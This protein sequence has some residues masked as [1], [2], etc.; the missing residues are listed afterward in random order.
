MTQRLIPSRLS[1]TTS[2]T[3]DAPGFHQNNWAPQL[4]T[5]CLALTLLPGTIPHIPPFTSQPIQVLKYVDDNILQEKINFE[6][7]VTDGYAFENNHAK[8]AQ[9][10]FWCIVAEAEACGMKLNVDKTQTMCISGVKSYNSPVHFFDRGRN[11]TK[12]SKEMRILGLTFS[13]QPDLA[14]QANAVIAWLWSRIWSLSHS[15]HHGLSES[16]LL[17][18]YKSSINPVHDYCSCVYSSSLTSTQ[19]NTFELL[20]AKALK[21]I[22]GNKHCYSSLLQCTRLSTLKVRRDNRNLKLALKAAA[23]PWYSHWFPLSTNRASST[24]G[25]PY[26]ESRAKTKTLFISLIF[27]KR[28]RLNSTGLAPELL[29]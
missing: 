12:P 21:N 28:W 5:C 29:D 4:L 16:D 25:R 17:Q 7:V 13:S 23:N 22:Y 26:Q 27:N 3:T 18:V 1:R 19:S 8:C 24:S 6:N 9:N 11:K 14:I 15:A 20:Q 10:L 2:L